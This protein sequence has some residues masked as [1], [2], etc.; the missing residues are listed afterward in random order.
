MSLI[1]LTYV[2]L[3]TCA[4]KSLL[5]ARGFSA[6]TWLTLRVLGEAPLIPLLSMKV[7]GN[8]CK[9]VRVSQ[10]CGGTVR[11]RSGWLFQRVAS[12]FTG[13]V[14]RMQSYSEQGLNDLCC[15]H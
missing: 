15:A 13:K 1:L 7:K 3:Y 6:Y 9:G 8:S 2:C 12:R 11:V 14:G 10:C 5:Q 4:A